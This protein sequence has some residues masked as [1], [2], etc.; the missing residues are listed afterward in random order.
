VL[1]FLAFCVVL[2]VLFVFV[3]CLVY[4]MLPLSLDRPF[5]IVRRFYAT[6]IHHRRR[7]VLLIFFTYSNYINDSFYIFGVDKSN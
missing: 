4:P 6:F 3:L 5:L 1:I 7:N 2:F